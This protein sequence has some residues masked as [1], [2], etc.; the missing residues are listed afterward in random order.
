MD[1]Y[2][3]LHTYDYKL[4]FCQATNDLPGDMQRCIW[5]KLNTYESQNRECPGAPRRIKQDSRFS[6]ERLGILVRKWR[7]NWG[8]PDSF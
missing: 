7:E 5:E 1:D 6:P 3:A 4:A 2:I 8:E